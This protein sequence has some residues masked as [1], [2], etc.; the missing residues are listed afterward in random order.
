LSLLVFPL[1]VTT[2]SSAIFV[3]PFRAFLRGGSVASFAKIQQKWLLTVT[4]GIHPNQDFLIQSLSQCPIFY[5]LPKAK[6]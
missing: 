4:A 5:D 1:K 2:F 6:L 3:L